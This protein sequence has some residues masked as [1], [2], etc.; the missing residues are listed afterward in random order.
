MERPTVDFSNRT[1]AK[2]EASASDV[3]AVGS[4]VCSPEEHGGHASEI[5]DAL[6]VVTDIARGRDPYT[7]DRSAAYRPEFHPE[8]IRSLCLVVSQLLKSRDTHLTAAT[9]APLDP[10]SPLE[11]QLRAIEKKAI[12]AALE[13]TKWNR[14][15]AARKL[16]MTFRALR[17]RLQAFGLDR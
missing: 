15:E 7:S 9:E 1:D 4:P 17:Y 13:E 2:S 3:S 10:N 6:R 12:L 5:A 8:T 14:T 11:N 16:G